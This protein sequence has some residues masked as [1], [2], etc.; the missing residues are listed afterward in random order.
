[1]RLVSLCGTVDKMV[2]KMET[3]GAFDSRN[4]LRLNL[5]PTIGS[6]S[7]K[8]TSLDLCVCTCIIIPICTN[9]CN[10]SYERQES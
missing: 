9:T 3:R 1:M 8:R 5:T 2:V 10:Y 4:W 7:E 6:L